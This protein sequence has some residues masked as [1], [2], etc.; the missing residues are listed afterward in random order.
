MSLSINAEQLCK[1][2]KLGLTHDGSIRELANRFFARFANPRHRK[3]AQLG[4]DQRRKRDDHF[5]A[6]N[7]VS[8]QVGEGEVVGIIGKNGAGKSTLLKLLSRI[9]SPTS[10]RAEIYGR[11]ASLLEVGTGFHPELTG[12]ENI[13]L[14]GTILGMTRAEIRHQLTEIVA[15]AGIE[16]FIDTP[17]K[18]YSSGM[19]VRL[20]FAV[21]AHLNPEI[22]IIDEVLAVGDVEFQKRCLGKMRHVAESGKTVLFVSHNLTSIRN[23]TT[24]CIVLSK[25]RVAFDGNTNEALQVYVQENL[26]TNDETDSVEHASRSFPGLSRDLE[27]VRLQLGGLHD[28]DTL[29]VGRDFQLNTTIRAN[30]LTSHFLLGLT[31]YAQDNT[32]IGSTFTEKL[33]PPKIGSSQEYHFQSKFDLAPGRYHCAISI[34]DANSEGQRI[35]DSVAGVLPFSVELSASDIRGWNAG[36]GAIRLPELQRSATAN[37]FQM[38]PLAGPLPSTRHT[39]RPQTSVFES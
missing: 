32:P 12:R 35:Y 31:V 15:F 26:Q 19:K 22:L 5:W 2:Y 33:T 10:G 39:P 27:F 16:K 38:S 21:A 3:V 14:N 29:Q 7:D 36:W 28:R 34:T 9:T 30:E 8:F 1:R 24:R 13:F 25:G 23:L 37:S 4:E 6:L 20:G 18:R 11:V 17:V